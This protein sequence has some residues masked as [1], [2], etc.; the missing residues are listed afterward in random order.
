MATLIKT[1]SSKIKNAK[2]SVK[3]YRKGK[4]DIQ[5]TQ[6]IA[7]FGLDSNPIADLVGLY[8]ATENNGEPVLVGF[9]QPEAV[10]EPGESRLFSSDKN[11]NTK[12]YL[13]MKADGTAE[14]GG[15]GNFLVKFNELKTAFDAHITEYNAH[16]HTGNIGAPTSPPVVPSTASIDAA[17]HSKIKT[18]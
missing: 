13:H 1:I 3:F 7:P 16:L 2:L 11:G 15:T 5:N 8:M 6:Q 12:Y 9:I 4:S 17:K 18:A 14:F 10:A